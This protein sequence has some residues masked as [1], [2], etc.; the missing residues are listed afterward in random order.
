MNHNP[1]F[2]VVIPCFNCEKHI[3]T[4]VESVLL[5]SFE[6][7]EIIIV[8]DGSFDNTHEILSE[9]KLLDNCIRIIYRNSNSGGPATP[10]NEGIAASNGEYICLLDSD[11]IWKKD[12]LKND[13]LYLDTNNADILFSGTRYFIGELS[14]I[15]HTTIPRDIGRFFLIRN[16]VPTSTLCLKKSTFFG[17]SMVFDVD[18]LLVAIED[19][20]FLLCS[21]LEKKTIRCRDGVDIYYRQDSDTSIYNRKNFS[22]LIR[23]HLYNL[24]KVSCK[25]SFSPSKIYFNIILL[26]LFFHAKKILNRL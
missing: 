17:K 3:R 22:M 4:T 10:R 12:K 24:I 18:P 11:D 25:F 13:K 8:D 7:F 14:N 23:R 20:H 9:L 19:F 1:F 21:Y 16:H 26:L 6:D 2:T 5:Q 15:V